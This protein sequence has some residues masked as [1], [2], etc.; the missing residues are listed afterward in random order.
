M[1][2][3]PMRAGQ[4]RVGEYLAWLAAYGAEVGKP[5][6]PYE[7]VRYKSYVQGARRAMTHVVYMKENQSLTWTGDT[8][9]HYLAFI[10]GDPLPG[11]KK[12][13]ATVAEP[14][15]NFAPEP[16]EPVGLTARRRKRLLARDGGD[17]WFC[18]T[19]MGDDCTLEHLV[20]QSR[21]GGNDAANTVL[22]HAACN[23]RAAN[24]SS[25]EKVQLR[26]QMR[27]SVVDV[28]THR[29]VL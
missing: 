26:E 21:G 11:A 4:F 16:V 13:K 18:G 25:S 3:L 15:T 5:T 10:A 6:N 24:L 22:A 1:R 29:S 12:P 14:P 27:A 17:C 9:S 7:L 20:P 28:K 8:M 19:P 23:N 2:N